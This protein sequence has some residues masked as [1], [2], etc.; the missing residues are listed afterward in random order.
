MT[1]VKRIDYT[2]S[3]QLAPPK[4][5]PNGFLRADGRIARIGVQEYRDGA[6]NIRKELRIEEEVFDAESLESFEQLPLTNDHPRDML[7]SENA[8][9][10]SVG[11]VAKLRRDVDYVVATIMITDA[12]A[13]EAAIKGRS[14][15]SNGYSCVLDAT[16][17]P[18]LI[19][20]YGPYDAIQRDI[21]GNHV[22]LVDNARA[23]AEARLRLDAD[24]AVSV[25]GGSPEPVI[26]SAQVESTQEISKMAQLKVDG[27]TFEIADANAQA[28]VDRAIASAKK[29]SEDKAAK[30]E[31]ALAE[32]KK[33]VSV[34]QAKH[35]SLAA[36]VKTDAEKMVQC[37][38]CGGS[39][40]ID[41]ETC[42]GCSGEGKVPAKGDRAD[43]IKRRIDRAVAL[44][45][46]ARASLLNEAQKHLS[47]NVKLD[48]LTDLEIKRQVVAA[49][50]PALKTQLEAK[51]DDASYIVTLYDA[52]IVEYAATAPRTHDL[53]RAGLGRAPEPSTAPAETAAGKF[54]SDEDPEKARLAMIKRQHEQYEAF[55][56]GTK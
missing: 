27:M 37:D 46:K 55:R 29:D 25:F 53:G 9:N 5:L 19:A 8:K 30:A 34:L 42:K 33:E 52:A 17:D 35:D 2:S 21:R 38:E 40:K 15:L 22:A 14:Q 26:A 47:A 20:K 44:G 36:E 49:L 45:V 31:L 48:A 39:G 41:G 3:G 1:R 54:D 28:V 7:D 23:G 10:H 24:D 51:K 18:E 6:G 56:K 11:N 32:A 4:K 12:K 43:S 50:R 16:Q 13:I